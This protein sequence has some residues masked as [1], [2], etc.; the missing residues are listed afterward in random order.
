M[1]NGFSDKVIMNASFIYLERWTVT[2]HE[3]RNR[4][5]HEIVKHVHDYHKIGFML[6]L[7]QTIFLCGG[8]CYG[9]SVHNFSYEIILKIMYLFPPLQHN[10]AIVQ[11]WI[12]HAVVAMCWNMCGRNLISG[13]C[14]LHHQRCTYWTP[15]SYVQNF[16]SFLIYYYEP[17][18][19]FFC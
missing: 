7:C 19:N 3:Y 15:E 16:E 14:L 10:L 12:T 11:K 6:F 13:W 5:H 4:Q 9:S 8:N 1:E 18:Y 17:F 2:L